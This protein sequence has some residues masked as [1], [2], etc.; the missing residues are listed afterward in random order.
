MAN[1]TKRAA[2]FLLIP[3]LLYSPPN[4]AIIE[5]LLASDYEVHVFS[6]NLLSTPTEYGSNVIT[7]SATYSFRW[8]AKVIL[9]PFWWS[10]RCISGTSEEPLA[11]VGL[12]AF[13]LKKKS[14]I[15]ADEIKAGSYRGNSSERW[16]NLC[17]WA[18][19]HAKFN[20]V[21]DQSRVSL[22]R[23][24]VPLPSQAQIIVY[25]GCFHQPPVPSVDYRK[26]LR[27]QW[28][29]PEQALV[30]ASSGGFNLTAGADWLINALQDRP[31][32]YAVIQPLGVDPLALFLL[33]NIPSINRVYLQRKRL[34]WNEAWRS[35]VGFDI[36]MA[37][38]TNQAPQFQKMGIS[39]N[40]L[41]MFIAMGVPIICSK[42]DSFDFVSR[43]ECGAVVSDYTE[44]LEAISY[45]RSN[46]TQMR[47]NCRRCFHDYIMPA[48]RFPSLSRAIDSL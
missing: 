43:Y 16:K 37:I 46:L 24:Y 45:I 40:R 30:L 18:M 9:D 21:N 6:P 28:H 15:L 27:Q 19:K 11:V 33:E 10:V 20:I 44:F 5:A 22:L 39:S 29:I 12:L 2:H 26:E 25:P 14:F 47:D 36:G 13:L 23:E 42:Q 31:D 7:H 1:L 32:L 3:E 41:C 34:G 38:Y 35:A 8:I 4:R 48:D 17:R